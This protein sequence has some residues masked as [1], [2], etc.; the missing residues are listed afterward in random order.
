MSATPRDLPQQAQ[1]EE[2]ARLL[3]A[4]AVPKLSPRRHLLLKEHLMDTIDEKSQRPVRLTLRLR[5]ALPV[6]L[7]AVAAL[8]AV[9]GHTARSAPADSATHGQAPTRI[10]DA[11]YILQSSAGDV[12]TLTILD[13]TRPVDTSRLQRDLD[14]L[15]IHSRVYAGEPGCHASAP[16]SPAPSVATSGWQISSAGRRTVLTVHR[17]L[18]PTD[19]QLFVYFPLADTD[20]ADGFRELEAGL[21]KSPAPTCMPAKTYTN[22]LAGQFP[23]ANR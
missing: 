4:A 15:G 8:A 12:V 21:M 18:I 6:G 5:L 7:A 11:A 14:R 22:P 17:Q 10:V 2:M 20:P 3:P 16:E 19:L 1:R 9:A 23:T 13:P